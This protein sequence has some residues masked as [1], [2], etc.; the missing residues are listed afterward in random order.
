MPVVTQMNNLI[1]R[2]RMFGV[3]DMRGG[4]VNQGDSQGRYVNPIEG[5]IVRR[6]V[7]VFNIEPPVDQFRADPTH[8]SGLPYPRAALKDEDLAPLRESEIVIV[9]EEPE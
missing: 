8:K 6:A 7:M 1:D 4:A 3:N 5:A 9:G 2:T